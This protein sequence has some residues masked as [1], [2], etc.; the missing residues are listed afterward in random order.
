M[1]GRKAIIENNTGD[2]PEMIAECLNC[3][4]PKCIYD[5]P[6]MRIAKGKKPTDKRGKPGVTYPYKDVYVTLTQA[7]RISGINTRVLKRRIKN[8]GMTLE[9]AIEK[10]QPIPRNRKE[11]KI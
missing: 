1:E 7:S 9:Q 3:Q 5:C 6:K 10:G 4:M 2:T 8:N 11:T